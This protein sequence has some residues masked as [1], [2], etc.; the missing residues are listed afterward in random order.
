MLELL[1]EPLHIR[2]LNELRV[3]LRVRAEGTAVVLKTITTLA[4]L[5]CCGKEW[6]LVSFALG[7]TVYASTILATYLK[8]YG[9]RMRLIPVKVVTK[10]HGTCVTYLF[11][12]PV[13][14]FV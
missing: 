2:A 4:V 13:N 5:L 8:E 9:L 14:I 10:L 6:S 7:Q 1:S 12:F 3:G 11:C